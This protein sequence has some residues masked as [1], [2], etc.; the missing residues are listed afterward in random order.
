M[1]NVSIFKACTASI[2]FA[3]VGF[4]GF[5]FAQSGGLG[6]I[7]SA[8]DRESDALNSEDR[9]R[10]QQFMAEK[11]EQEREVAALRAE[12]NAARREGERLGAESQDNE[13]SIAE[14]EAELSL[15][16][17][18]FGQLLGE[19]RSSAGGLMP[20]L[21][22]SM[23]NFDPAVNDPAVFGPNGRVGRLA[24]IAEASTLPERADLDILPK[25]ILAEMV[26]QSEV[27]VFNASVANYTSDGE[28]QSAELMRIGVFAMATAESTPRFI[29]VTSPTDSSIAPSLKIYTKPLSPAFSGPM[30]KIINA[31]DG[32]AVRAPVDAFKG[33]MFGAQQQFPSMGERLNQGGIVGYIVGVLLL[34][35]FVFGVFKIVTQGLHYFAMKATS[36]T[37]AG[38][39]GNSLARVIQVYDDNKSDNL[40]TIELKLDE[41]IL[42]ETPAIDRFNGVVKVLAA[43][44]PLMGLLGTVIGMIITFTMI[45]IFGA[46]DPKLMAGGISTALMTTV[47]GLVSAIPLLLLY[48]LSAAIARAN[49]QLLDGQAAGLIAE[50]AENS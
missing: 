25:A 5:A 33:G 9:A 49:V 32:A 27:K 14:K 50:K 45:T 42:K 34:I 3:A 39:N 17:G 8:L 13:A 38:G 31:G 12:Y 4:T 21:S 36:R 6:G 30:G 22:R 19:F 29:E 10:L 2:L 23:A 18:D 43:I 16:A 1:K 24:Q 41:Q 40:Q 15:A 35:G 48:A 37:R 28:T 7:I 46:G 20:E 26:G 11:S 47:F 44:S